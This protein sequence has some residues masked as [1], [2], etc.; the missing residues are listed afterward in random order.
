LTVSGT[1]SSPGTNSAVSGK[2]NASG[3]VVVH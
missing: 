3:N 2:T 1:V